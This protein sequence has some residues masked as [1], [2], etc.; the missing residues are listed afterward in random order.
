M[1]QE[2]EV[3]LTMLVDASYSKEDIKRFMEDME[4]TYTRTAS[5]RNRWEVTKI[6]VASVKEE[7]EIYSTS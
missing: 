4:Q 5:S 1:T 2:V 6:V 7:S 3:V